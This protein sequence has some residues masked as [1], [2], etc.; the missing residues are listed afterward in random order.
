MPVG[1]TIEAKNRYDTFEER[2]GVN[3]RSRP[4]LDRVEQHLLVALHPIGLSFS[5]LRSR[6]SF[7][8]L[9]VNLVGA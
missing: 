8:G 2:P 5:L 1:P 7:L 3:A 6:F 4:R 9:G